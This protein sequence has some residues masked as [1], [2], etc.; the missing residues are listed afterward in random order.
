MLNTESR[1]DQKNWQIKCSVV[2]LVLQ[3]A[4]R[5]RCTLTW[6][7]VPGLSPPPLP[8]LSK[9]WT[10]FLQKYEF[11]ETVFMTFCD[12]ISKV[13]TFQLYVFTYVVS[14]VEVHR[15]GHRGQALVPVRR[16][17]VHRRGNAVDKHRQEGVS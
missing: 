15:A 10:S 6:T 7:S 12:K 17:R 11:P 8:M 13:T 16:L 4:T 5:G 2:V 14:L 1:L 3:R 9:I